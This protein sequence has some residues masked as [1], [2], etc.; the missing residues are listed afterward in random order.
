MTDAPAS[1]FS[2]Y[3][4]QIYII[5]L[6]SRPDRLASTL[7]ELSGLGI[8]RESGQIRVPEAPMPQDPNG[9]PSKGVYGNF[10]SHLGIL[11]NIRS[12]G[13]TRALILEDDAIFRHK[14]RTQAEQASL[15]AQI[16]AHNWTMW[17]GGH[18]LGTKLAK[19]PTGV[20]P[21]TL[22]FRWAHCYA[23]HRRGLDHLISYLEATA[24]RARGHPEGG[25]MYIDGAFS[26]YRKL[27]P[28]RICLVSNPVLSVQK[29]T[30]SNLGKVRA[31]DAYT[32]AQP[33]LNATR[34]LRDNIWKQTGI[35]LTK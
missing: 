5:N 24:E 10:L 27:Y 23:V 6:P 34:S 12:R 13:L 15:I 2:H 26:L 35:Y 3:F 9:F 28:D 33:L 7:K 20:V 16:E 8:T 14:L 17:F 4:E 19:K 31:Y 25:K 32:L 22:P 11:R 1:D 21:T 30:T 29:G 18:S